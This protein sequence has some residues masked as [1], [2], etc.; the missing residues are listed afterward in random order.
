MNQENIKNKLLASINNVKNSEKE[1][2]YCLGDSVSIT[3]DSTNIAFKKDNLVNFKKCN[4]ELQKS[5]AFLPY[6]VWE[7][8]CNDS[9]YYH[10]A[11]VELSNSNQFKLEVYKLEPKDALFLFKIVDNNS[12]T[13]KF[14]EI[15]EDDAGNYA[16]TYCRDNYLKTLGL[17]DEF[18]AESNEFLYNHSLL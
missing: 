15:V 16:S 13:L 10:E 12:Y 5:I 6:M 2:R 18:I 8:Y 4:T 9:S 7:N 14:A 11:I 17:Y 1:L 3:D